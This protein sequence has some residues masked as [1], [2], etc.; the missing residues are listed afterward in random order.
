MGAR[1]IRD[2]NPAG[3]S[4]PESIISIDG[5]LFFTADLGSGSTTEPPT[6]EDTSDPDNDSSED[7]NENNS[8]ESNNS[9]SNDN[10]ADDSDQAIGQGLALTK[11][12]GTAKGTKVLKEFQ[13]INDLV[14][15]NGELYFI[16]DDGSGP[17][18]TGGN[19]L[20]RSDGTARGTAVVKDLYPGAD[21]NF[22]QDLFEI[23]SVLFYAAINSNSEEGVPA[24]NGYE[25]WR[26]EG[27]SVGTPMFK[28]IVPDQIITEVDIDTE[29]DDETGVTEITT[30]ITTSRVQND[31]FPKGFT[32]VNGNIFFTAATPYFMEAGDA[33]EDILNLLDR[34]IIGGIELWF[35]DGTESG[36]RPIVINSNRYDYYAPND[37]EYGYL[38]ENIYFPDYG[39]TTNSASSFPRE[40]TAFESN[41]IFVANDGVHGFELWKIDDEGN[42][43][44]LIADLSEGNTSSSPEQLTVVGDRLYFTADTGSGRKLWSTSSGLETPVL[45]NGAGDD[46]KDLTAIEDKLY[47]SSKSELGREL[48]VADGNS[49]NLVEDIN[50]GT[51]SSSPS[52]FTATKNQRKGNIETQLFFTADGG[53]RGVELWSLDLANNSSKPQRYDDIVDG[54]TSS[55][56][57]QLVNAEQRLY[58]TAD[59]GESGR[60]LWTLGVTIQ[61]PTGPSNGEA[62]AVIQVEEQTKKVFQYSS[63]S[64]VAWS[65]N[66]GDDSDLFTIN[67]K[68]WLKFNEK[69]YYNSP[70]DSNRDNIYQVRVRAKDQLLGTTSDQLVD[71]KVTI[72][73]GGTDQ[74]NGTDGDGADNPGSADKLLTSTLIKNINSGQQ[75]SNPSHLTSLKNEFLLLAADNGKKGNELW[76]SNGSKKTTSL[77][78]DI[79]KGFEGSNPSGFTTYKSLSYFSADNGKKGQELW[80]SNGKKKGTELI[81]DVNPGAAGSFPSD[82]LVIDQRLF[83]AA[84]DGKHGRELWRYSTKHQTSSLVLDIQT[85][86]NIGS[87]PGELTNVNGQIMFAADDQIYGRELWISDGTGSGTRLLDDINPGGLNSN[88]S[89]LSV[90]NGKLY[91]TAENYLLGGRQ[92]FRLDS[93][94][95][96]GTTAIVLEN[97]E[98]T[99]IEPSDLHTSSDQLFFS[100]ETTQDP[101]PEQTPSTP[102]TGGGSNSGSDPGG[103]MIAADGIEAQAREYIENY[104]GRIDSYRR[105]DDNADALNSAR[106]WADALATSSLVENNDAS[107]AED[108]NQYFQPLSDQ[109]LSTSLPIRIPD[110]IQSTAA[111]R[112]T[113]TSPGDST[114]TPEAEDINDN[115]GRELW[116]SNGE[117]DGHQLLKDIYPGAG[118]SNP[119]SFHTIGSKT[120]FSAD[121]GVYGEELWVTDGTKAGTYLVSDINE[122]IGDSSPRSINDIDGTIYFSAKTDQYGRE[123]WRLEE[124]EQSATRIIPNDAGNSSLKAMDGNADE[125]RF[126]MAGQFGKRQADRITGFDSAEGDQLALGRN[127]FDSLTDIDLVTVTSKTQ[128][129]TQSG[130]STALIYFEPKGQLYFNQ[131][132]DE[133]G[134]GEDGGLFAILKGGPDLS[135]SAFR[136][137]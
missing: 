82:L 113:T 115:L 52:N 104:N 9:N 32:A 134:Y 123:L 40:L 54:P 137:L 121:D 49:A 91:F 111:R 44:E 124:N 20:W 120:Y 65:L 63:D 14:E 129:A 105:F 35:S 15:V 10:T 127:V 125:F 103:F 73:N 55:E 46:P 96:D 89:N 24:E 28:N 12:D 30:S 25:L 41:L 79:N 108:W 23:D 130:S 13:S 16:A 21:P 27:N 117:A 99:G 86:S 47:F 97:G 87:N 11:S 61:G 45:V 98:N 95:N 72:F 22:P 57:R 92:I 1:L 118:S 50:P 85:R 112:S 66:G 31:S 53:E 122:G 94:N 106:Y 126:E 58:F 84:D 34:D 5:L 56:P 43:H 75:S 36:T 132:G 62:S 8:K 18:A 78:K 110:G 59:D 37:F 88:P 81:S 136:I 128:L 70:V 48:W 101:T 67:K 19:R 119:R 109:L 114:E 64:D 93:Q 133:S 2:L 38:P 7:S 39:F 76:S 135:E 3:S 71:V 26:R 100:A 102:S 17:D 60:E 51:G 68:G 116:I 69:P 29:T 107:L 74:G 33:Q 83:F 42:Q 77:L 90:L 4:S 131:N 80:V 6:G